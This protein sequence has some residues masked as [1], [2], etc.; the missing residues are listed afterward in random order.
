MVNP[1]G[2]M[3]PMGLRPSIRYFRVVGIFESGFYDIDDNWTYTS[4]EATQQ[5]LSL[6]DVVNQVELKLDD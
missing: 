6:E 5:A 4:L 3:T 1:Q 2:E